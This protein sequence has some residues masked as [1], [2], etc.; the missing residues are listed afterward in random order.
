MKTIA[1]V[2]GTRPEIIKLAPLVRKLRESK[3]F[4]VHVI[5]S[6]QHS[7][8]AE[9][10]FGS[11]G[12]KPDLAFD[13]MK[14]NQSPNSFLASLLPQLEQAFERLKPA[15]V[16]VQG[17]TTTALGGALAAF[18]A[19]IPVIHVEAGLRTGNFRSP[20][21]EEMNRV[22]ISSLTN[23][24][25]CHSEEASANLANEGIRENV[26]VVGNTVVDALLH[27]LSE[28]ES[29]RLAVSNQ[30]RT[31]AEQYPSLILVTGHRREN[32]DAPLRNLC[33]AL[34]KVTQERSS[35]GVIFPVHLNPNVQSVVQ[36]ELG[37]A[38]QIHLVPPLDYPSFVWLMKQSSLIVSDS[39]GVQEE[40]PSLGKHVFVT[41]SNT[42][43]PE[44]VAA[45]FAEVISL[46]QPQ[47]LENRLRSYFVEK[48]KSAFATKNPFGDGTASDK[49]VQHLA[50]KL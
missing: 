35:V 3:Q 48:E 44:A 38:P 21:P 11:F 28:I 16:I 2:L 49:I 50:A 42:E 36:A 22:L 34:V 17:D 30:I 25:F 27:V 24:H 39:G 7:S 32:F 9:Q 8:M 43:R 40:A 6:G 37:T 31:L 29:G 13:L 41:R 12:L 15:G 1:V 20:F 47:Q 5:A 23:F 45:G 18:H 46:E 4:A 10:A 19:E 14:P 26:F 33:R